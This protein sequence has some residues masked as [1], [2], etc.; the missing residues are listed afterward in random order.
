M[1]KAF[2]TVDSRTSLNVP[3]TTNDD[4]SGTTRRNSGNSNASTSGAQDV[5]GERRRLSSSGTQ[6]QSNARVEYHTNDRT[7]ATSSA[8]TSVENY[9]GKYF[10]ELANT[11]YTERI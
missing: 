1:D 2:Y 8:S 3:L 6:G 9:S 7:P 10:S 4:S 5:S 11:D